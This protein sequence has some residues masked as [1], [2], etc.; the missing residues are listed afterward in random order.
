MKILHV[1][2]AVMPA[3]SRELSKLGPYRF[4]DW[5]QYMEL[6]PG[7][8]EVLKRDLLKVSEQMN[9]DITFLHIQRAG[10][11]DASVAS[12]LKG[13]V[14]NYTYDVALPIPSWYE[15]VGRKINLTLFCDEPGVQD[16]LEKGI[17]AEFMQVGYDQM[18]FRPNGSTG[19]FLNDIVFLG[20]NYDDS[21]GFHLTNQRSEMVKFLKDTY[22]HTFKVYGNKW[23]Y[24]DGNLMYREYK[25][26]E[27]YRSAKIGISIS[28]FDLE[29]YTSDRT[30]RIMGC[31]TFC[32]I[33]WYPGIEKDFTDG[34]HLRVWKTFDE[35]KELID[36]YIEHE[37]ERKTIARNGYNLV[38]ETATWEHR[39][40]TI[41]EMANAKMSKQYKSRVVKVAQQFH[42]KEEIAPEPQQPVLPIVSTIIPNH[43]IEPPEVYTPKEII[44]LNQQIKI[45]DKPGVPLIDSMFVHAKI[46]ESINYVWDRDISSYNYTFLTDYDV[47]KAPSLTDKTLYA[48]IMESPE[49]SVDPHN[50]VLKNY[51]KFKA[52]FT[53]SKKLIDL[54][55]NIFKFTPAS[56]CWIRPEDQKI[57]PKTE[58]ISIIASDK[59][60][61][62]GHRLRHQIL[63]MLSKLRAG[64]RP[65]I[66]GRGWNE[67][68]NKI[69]GLAPF[70]FSIAIENTKMDYY[71]TE[72]LLDC[73]M[74]GTVPI[75]YGCPSIGKFFD[76]RG[77]IVFNSMEELMRILNTLT[78][79]KY[80]E[81]LPYIQANFETCKKY[82]TGE[83][84]L[85]ENYK[86][87]LLNN[88]NIKT[89]LNSPLNTFV[90]KI[91]CINLDR[92]TDR[93]ESVQKEFKKHGV[94]ATRWSAVDGNTVIDN[95]HMK[96][97]DMPAPKNKGAVGCLRSHRAVLQDA[98]DNKYKKI[99]IFEDDV[100][101]TSNFNEALENYLKN[102][103]ADWDMLYL[104]CHW[105]G[106]NPPKRIGNS[107][108]HDL[109][110]CFGIFGVIMK[111]T[112]ISKLL[113]ASSA[114]NKPM[115]DY[116]CFD[117]HPFVKKY[118]TIPFLIKVAP[119]FSDI[120]NVHSEY[121][122]VSQYFK[123]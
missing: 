3:I 47:D 50:Y 31:G 23:P 40:K 45:N 88:R 67:I 36:Y 110:K 80:E 109:E 60:F 87:I 111:D 26:A 95:H 10:V 82:L 94:N 56:R 106:L 114:E 4:F 7:A 65:A 113:H 116:I 28:H 119:D 35:L 14:I 115:D 98:I 32:L 53:H 39:M 55:P 27:C 46:D 48:W 99:C 91:Y 44:E 6:G 38:I 102:A 52:V 75:F 42:K 30:F 97:V 25:E 20:N 29:R 73:F 13:F 21:Q 8:K 96:H 104:G 103:P 63:G 84:Y 49:L 89:E 41:N 1:G 85:Y 11:I 71:F 37:E 59:N 105:H 61:T 108:I 121:T 76:E 18:V 81:M 9:P 66:F 62:S 69:T 117:V 78:A 100:I 16:F 58:L 15:E 77:I 57:W 22:G 123:P 5:T 101:L 107:N 12:L 19:D 24:Q 79:S 120:G 118:V 54:N 93:W 86:E 112:M 70:M 34:V 68:E 17:E 72:K 74:T 90:D 83:D 33:K 92:R 51:N 43:L 122:I 2:M 64:E